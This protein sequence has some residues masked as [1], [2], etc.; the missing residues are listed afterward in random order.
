V[1]YPLPDG[2][3]GHPAAASMTKEPNELRL[4]PDLVYEGGA[5]GGGAVIFR[6]TTHAAL[7][8]NNCTTCHIQ[9]FK[10]LHGERRTSHDEMTA[11]KACG[12]CHDGKK[13]FGITDTE[14]CQVCHSGGSGQEAKPA[15]AH[16]AE[17]ARTGPRDIP[18]AKSEGSPGR[19]TFSHASHGGA[20]AKCSRCHPALFPMK[21]GD[22][23]LDY[24]AMLQGSSC[25]A[26]HNGKQVFGV[27]DSERCE[28]CHAAEGGGK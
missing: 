4:P 3:D 9:I 14:S 19:V 10:I 25:G 13:A 6:H 18:L 2:K 24:A 27:D 7:S 5:E 8:G 28:R 16:P 20:A 21:V 1:C 11:G 22:K 15:V 12:A 23:P 26:C 17:A